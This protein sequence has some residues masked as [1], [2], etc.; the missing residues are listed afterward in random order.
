MLPYAP[1]CSLAF[2]PG[3]PLAAPRV[4]ARGRDAP[5]EGARR[6]QTSALLADVP[7][8]AL[9]PHTMARHGN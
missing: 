4:A 5:L 2:R 8:A 6:P 9:Q 1:C 3:D 7:P